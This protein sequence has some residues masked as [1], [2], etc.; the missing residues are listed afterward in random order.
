MALIEAADTFFIG[1]TH[2]TRGADASHRGG[3][4]GFVR[5]NPGEVWWADYRGNNMFNTLGN[6]AVDPTAA[7][8]FPDF[9]TGRTLQLSGTAATE[10]T[11]RAAAGGD[12]HGTGRVV[13]FHIDQVVAGDLLAARANTTVPSRRKPPL[14]T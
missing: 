14:T 6:L 10:W 13:H 4:T 1:T 11:T 9:A 7:L 3:P 5:A 12:D 8:L 2:P